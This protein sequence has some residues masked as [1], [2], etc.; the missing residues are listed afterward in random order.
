MT[1]NRWRNDSAVIMSNIENIRSLLGGSPNS[2]GV[3]LRAVAFLTRGVLEREMDRLWRVE[4]GG[5]RRTN[6]QTPFACLK[7]LARDGHIDL[8]PV[9]AEDIHSAWAALS[10]ACHH[11]EYDLTPTVSEL[12]LWIGQVEQLVEHLKD[13]PEES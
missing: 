1:A 12:E 2:K 8:D 5:T 10:R 7:Q 6:R 4:F 3:W 9:M 11:H 13:D